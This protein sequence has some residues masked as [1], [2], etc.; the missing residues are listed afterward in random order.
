MTSHYC[1]ALTKYTICW[2]MGLTVSRYLQ[3][4]CFCSDMLRDILSTH[5]E[6]AA[7]VDIWT[8]LQPKEEEKSNTLHVHKKCTEQVLLN[9]LHSCT[10][11][12]LPIISHLSP[13]A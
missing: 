12:C 11:L 9:S 1:D 2:M 4:E 10:S 3:V 7:V 6:N 13:F 8:N 5:L